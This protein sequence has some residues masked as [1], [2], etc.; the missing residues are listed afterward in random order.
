M[1]NKVLIGIAKRTIEVAGGIVLG[2]LLSSGLK[3]TVELTKKQLNKNHD[4]D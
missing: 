2:T 4:C 3:K 1:M